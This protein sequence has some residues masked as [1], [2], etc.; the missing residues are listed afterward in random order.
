[1]RRAA[2]LFA[3]LVLS[4]C[5]E[6]PSKKGAGKAAEQVVAKD[7]AAALKSEAKNIEAAADA[8]AKLVEE[9]T[10]QEIEGLEGNQIQGAD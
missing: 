3:A 9:E 6:E 10:N 1:M 8:A 2:L 7:E 4:A 5:V